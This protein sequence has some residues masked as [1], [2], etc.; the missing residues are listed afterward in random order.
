MALMPGARLE[1]LPENSTQPAIEPTQLIAHTAVDAPGRTRLP[2]FFARTDVTVESHFWIPL[3]GEIVQMMD[4]NVRADANRWANRRAISIETEDE[5]D[6]VGIPWTDAQLASIAEIIR[7]AHRVHGIPMTVCKAWN[8]PGLGYH[9]MWGAPSPWTPSHGKTCPGPTRIRQFHDV[10]IPSLTQE[11]PMTNAEATRVVTTVY[12][13]ILH[14]PHDDGGKAYWIKKAVD[15]EWSREDLFFNMLEPSA[16]EVGTMQSDMAAMKT[17]LR[18]LASS[19]EAV[20]VAIAQTHSTGP[21][22]DVDALAD[23]IGVRLAAR[24]AS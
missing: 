3:D 2:R 10:L 23:I 22:V 17:E 11:S 6:P 14:R 9:A 4:T 16:K 8:T 19:V 1:L 7:W 20:G 15:D 21:A 13:A 18:E 12:A 24:L 5:G